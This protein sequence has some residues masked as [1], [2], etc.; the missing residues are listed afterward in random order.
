MMINELKKYIEST[1]DDELLKHISFDFNS[2][3]PWN[4]WLETHFNAGFRSVETV[5]DTKR[6]GKEGIAIVDCEDLRRVALYT[7]KAILGK[8]NPLRFNTKI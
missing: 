2:I 5:L 7:V 8:N 4:G 6:L 1:C 3:A